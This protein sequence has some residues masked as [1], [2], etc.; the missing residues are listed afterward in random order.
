LNMPNPVQGSC[1][2]FYEASEL[3][4]ESD[5]PHVLLAGLSGHSFKLTSWNITRESL[6]WF[7]REMEA[8]LERLERE[9]PE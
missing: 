5:T 1:D 3:L 8:F 4:R 2:F 7:K 6:P 9:L